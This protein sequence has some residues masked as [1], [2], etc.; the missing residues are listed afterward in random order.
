ML[1]ITNISHRPNCMVHF[2]NIQ[3]MYGNYQL[4]FLEN[5]L[6]LDFTNLL[7]Q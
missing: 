4:I 6:N 5:E 2:N 7:K 3:K 1:L